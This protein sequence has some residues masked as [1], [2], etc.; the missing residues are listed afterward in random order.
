MPLLRKACQMGANSTAIICRSQVFRPASCS[1]VPDVRPTRTRKD[2]HSWE[3]NRKNWIV[4]MFQEREATASPP[5]YPPAW[6]APLDTGNKEI[7]HILIP[8][9][10]SIVGYFT[11][12]PISLWTLKYT[13][14]DKPINERRIG[15]DL[16]VRSHIAI[17]M[18]FTWEGLRKTTKELKSS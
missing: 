4:F 18:V 8:L 10:Q 7:T 13:R 6:L 11:L 5:K 1:R 12:L 9:T 3:E 17:E 15:K 2:P 14:N 16:K